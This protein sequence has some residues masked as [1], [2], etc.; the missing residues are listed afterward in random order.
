MSRRRSYQSSVGADDV[1]IRRKRNKIDV[2]DEVLPD[3]D[4]TDEPAPFSELHPDFAP[5][6]KATDD[7]TDD[8]IRSSD[9]EEH[10]AES[11]PLD[12]TAFQPTMRQRIDGMR[13]YADRSRGVFYITKFPDD[14]TWGHHQAYNM[15]NY[16]AR[17]DNYP[18]AVWV[19]GHIVALKFAPDSKKIWPSQVYASVRPLT[20]D[21]MRAASQI[22][23]LYSHPRKESVESAFSTIIANKFQNIYGSEEPAR[24]FVDVYDAQ[25]GMKPRKD[26]AHF[27]AASLKK[28]DFILMEMKVKK[29]FDKETAHLAKGKRPWS[30]NFTLSAVFLL[31]EGTGATGDDDNVSYG[32]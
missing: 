32:F 27:P 28:T 24:E 26:L 11:A 2:S 16:L 4:L 5:K 6:K 3:L 13:K 19:L 1:D 7:D 21:D 31:E 29:R 12:L 17:A 15:T 18:I 8:T 9:S 10:R 25:L 14:L 30:I 20:K 23:R 22:Q